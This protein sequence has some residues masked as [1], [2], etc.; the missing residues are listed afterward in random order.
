MALHVQDV[1][2]CDFQNDRISKLWLADPMKVDFKQRHY[3]AGL[4]L[5]AGTYSTKEFLAQ[6]WN[7]EGAACR[8][9]GARLESCSH[10]LEQSAGKLGTP[11]LQDV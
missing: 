1:G 2:V 11:A 3:I 9:C 5:Q 7:K 4:V 6:G 10:I 8:C